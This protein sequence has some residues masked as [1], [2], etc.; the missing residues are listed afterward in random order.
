M[1]R[2]SRIAFVGRTTRVAQTCR[3]HTNHLRSYS[4]FHQERPLRGPCFIAAAALN[5]RAIGADMSMEWR[6]G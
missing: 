5:A 3:K 2:P 6:N 1:L 4:Q